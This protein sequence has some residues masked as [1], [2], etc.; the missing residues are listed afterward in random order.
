MN[1][2]M[3]PGTTAEVY[4][5]DGSTQA[6][7]SLSISITE[8]T[9][10]QN[11]PNAMPAELPANS[12]YT[13]AVEI[14]AD[15]AVN[16][17]EGK[18]VILSRPIP[19]YINNFL[20]FP[21]GIPVPV[22]YYNNDKG[23]W[24]SSES[25]VILEIVS[26]TGGMAD[27][28]TDGDE[29]AEDQ[30][31]LDGLGITPEEQTKLATLYEAGTSLWRFEVDHFSSWDAN[32][33]IWPPEGAENPN[34][35][36]PKSFGGTEKSCETLSY[37][38]I[39]C[40][41]Q[42]LA[43][44]F[45]LTGTPYH[46]RYQSDRT[47]GR[48]DARTVKVYATGDTLP[49]TVKRI[50]LQ[51]FIAGQKRLDSLPA[52][53]NQ[54][55]DFTWNG[56]D[57]YGR[58]VEGGQILTSRVCYVY[59]G[60]YQSV[61][62]FGYN[63][64]G[65]SIERGNG[66]GELNMCQEWKTVI[67]TYDARGAG[68]G[69]LN[70]S[71]H[72]YFD[73]VAKILY[74]GDGTKRNAQHINRMVTLFAGN[75]TVGTGGDG[76]LATEAE[77]SSPYGLVVDSK[78]NMYVSSFGTHKIR[79]I[80]TNGIITT[81]AGTG[82]IGFSGD[83]GPAALAQFWKPW[84][85][86]IDRHDNIYVADSSNHRV[87]K[88]DSQGI[89]TTVAGTTSWGFSGD[90]ELAT[91]AELRSPTDVAV[92]RD[93]NIYIADTGNRRIRRVTPD[94]IISTY[95]G[96]GASWHLGQNGDGGP[97]TSARLCSSTNASSQPLGVSVDHEGDVYVTTKFCKR[98]RRITSD[99]II[100][101]I[102]GREGAAGD[103]FWE[104]GGPA[105][106]AYLFGPRDVDIDREGNIYIADSTGNR[107]RKVGTDGIITTFAGTGEVGN[108]KFLQPATATELT[109]VDVALDHESNVYVQTDW[110]R[111]IARIGSPFPGFDNNDIVISS[112][113][114][115]EV[116]HFNPTGKHLETLNS[117]TGNQTINFTYDANGLL[118]QI[119]DG[120]NNI[121]A[122]GRLNNIV[123]LTSPF[124]PLTVITLSNNNYA[125][126]IKNPN[127]EEVVLSYN[128]NNLLETFT[129]ARNN[130]T[131]FTYN[132]LGRLIKDENILG[133]FIGLD[134]SEISEDK[135]QVTK[136]TAMNRTT[137]Y[138]VE[139]LK[140]GNSK[141]EVQ[142]SSGFIAT[143]D[144]NTNGSKR[145]TYADGT[146]IETQEE[147][148]PRF[149]M[150][151]PILDIT[152]STPNGLQSTINSSRETVLNDP[153]DLLN[154][155]SQTDTI[156]ING[157]TFTIAYDSGTNTITSTTPENRQATSTID[158]QGRVTRQEITGIEPAN[159]TYDGNGRL[160]SITQGTAP[161][162][163]DYS[164]TYDADGFLETITDPLSRTVGFSYDNNGRVTT[165][166]MPDGREIGYTYDA[167][168]NVTSITPPGR[169]AHVFDY[170]E[171]NLETL[172]DPPNIGIPEDRTQY[173]YNLDKQLELITRP[174]GQVI[175]LNYDGGGRLNQVIIDRGNIDFSYDPNT[176]NLNTI[177]DP[178]GGSIA[179][180]YDG[181]LLLST[182][183]SGEV[184]GQVARMYDNDFRVTQRSVN[185]A[186]PVIFTYDNDS[187]LTNA[188]DLT[189]TRD[190]NNGL[191][192]GTTLGNITTQITYSAFG[193]IETY[194]ATNGAI[195]VFSATYTRDYLG[196]ITAKT[197]AVQGLP[198]NY[199]Y[200]Y[201]Q[202][203]R[204]EEAS[205]NAI[206]NTYAYDT[207]GNRLT[208]AG[209]G[210]TVNGVYDDQDRLIS[211]G[212][213]T[214]TYNANGELETK[215]TLQGVTT[216]QYDLLGNLI[217][218]V[219]PGN[220]TIEYVI[221]GNNRRVG[222]KVDGVLVSAWLYKDQLNPIAELNPDGS[223]KARFVYGTKSNVPDYMVKDGVAYRIVSDHLGSTRVVVKVDDGTIAQ[224]IDYDEYGMVIN[225]TNPG[226]QPFYYAGGLY[227]IHTKLVR[228]G[229]RD[230]E[231][232]S[233]KWTR[234]D[235]ARFLAGDTNLYGYTFNDPVNWIDMDGLAPNDK[236]YGLPADFWRWYHRQWKEKGAPDASKNEAIE[237]FNE[238]KR[239][240]K[241]G[242]DGTIRRFKKPKFRGTGLKVTC[243][244]LLEDIAREV[245]GQA[246]MAGSSEACKVFEFLGGELITYD[247]I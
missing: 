130:P 22:G 204:L 218:S 111:R 188:G 174:D 61:P 52:E 76:G 73:P 121:T 31:T 25:G 202:A 134:R 231:A 170:N 113:D 237:A 166:T 51:F 63:G 138:S 110:S 91:N 104:D 66:R 109:P 70:I 47:Q 26:I 129:D 105:T 211:Y 74:R 11:G 80:D 40:E 30:F 46:L 234:K 58:V 206:T 83:G 208:K 199:S 89:I 236:T 172:Y 242:P 77:I 1:I 36:Q 94:G 87:R 128:E 34:M 171:I 33:G 177:D 147:A 117:L 201:D 78:G 224:Q 103:P 81:Y 135:F 185:G 163:R 100:N 127:Q 86:A 216:Y 164:I 7:D 153:T 191:I 228:F 65:A 246:C 114:G 106:D 29:I 193:E 67:G 101:S 118:H 35:P 175:D 198:N 4:L 187:L 107:I 3:L 149:G 221:D 49:D 116:Y 18:D 215:T 102:A 8:Y 167:N 148:D 10:G 247:E 59:D 20:D 2:F 156:D 143:T 233:G 182:T 112:E 136:T 99:G 131:T 158:G 154:I 192:T 123:T 240:G 238:W 53:L 48:V 97:A 183:W 96:T 132:P 60:Q 142:D 230:Y 50:D 157:R 184:T 186:N 85:L 39:E 92:D 133:G 21:V 124:G 56:K 222:K 219:I 169:P 24:V 126:S 88:I 5:E 93:G 64:N 69:G 95:A 150:Q 32:F 217:T 223:L 155:E 19:V 161:D 210:G 203:G 38:I 144:I 159:F 152:V 190:P 200:I 227:D 212:D 119:T 146:I 168:G 13:Y 37:S 14:T 209:P 57:A 120:D 68:L 165:Q 17:V 205:L 42:T 55:Y 62:E 173:T 140:N 180:A 213:N 90:G 44:M 176:G 241:P 160:Q 226:F 16:R 239:R 179:Y 125:Q 115:T 27:I 122:I 214:Y 178:D 162:N 72:H 141:R 43:E 9:V 232:E 15:E 45:D 98:V 225:D 207:N 151:S 244:P 79:K 84:G 194:S 108:F 54:T 245:A 23:A 197:E 145:M 243:P 71:E 6:T 137:L 195:D 189:V 75:G 196:R 28:D 220:I 12:A 82:T 229:A 41:N 139:D 235:P 181:S